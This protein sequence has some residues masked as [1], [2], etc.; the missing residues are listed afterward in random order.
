LLLVER[1]GPMDEVDWGVDDE[2][3][4]AAVATAAAVTAA[5]S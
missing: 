3:A 1:S 5:F 4:A 2:D